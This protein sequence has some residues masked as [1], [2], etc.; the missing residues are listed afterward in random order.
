[1]FPS[2]G[3]GLVISKRLVEAVSGRSRDA[4]AGLFRLSP[5]LMDNAPR[6]VVCR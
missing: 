4:R 1:V 2:A 6:I 5:L 3:L